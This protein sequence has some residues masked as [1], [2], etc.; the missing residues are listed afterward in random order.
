MVQASIL[1]MC[2]IWGFSHPTYST[3][4]QSQSA[5]CLRGT[6]EADDSCCTFDLDGSTYS[7]RTTTSPALPS[8]QVNGLEVATTPFSLKCTS[9]ELL[10]SPHCQLP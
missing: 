1:A 4:I 9:G 10:S 3:S 7:H 6:M 8:I 2:E 5:G